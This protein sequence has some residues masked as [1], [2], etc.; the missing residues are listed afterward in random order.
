MVRRPPRASG[1]RPGP[2][3]AL[4][5]AARRGAIF[6]I[7]GDAAPEAVVQPLVKPDRGGVVVADLEADPRPPV[8]AGDTL[9]IGKEG[10]GQPP[11]PVPG[12]DGDRIEPRHGGS[13]AEDKEIV[14]ED[15]DTFADHAAGRG[16]RAHEMPE[17][18]RRQAIR[19]EGAGLQRQ[20][21]VDIGERGGANG[22]GFASS[23]LLLRECDA[24]SRKNTRTARVSSTE[25]AFCRESDR[26]AGPPASHRP[27]QAR[28]RIEQTGPRR[29]QTLTSWRGLNG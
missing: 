25:T 29:H 26:C 7:V 24:D 21:A 2:V 27:S 1:P 17:A 12:I 6:V 15:L 5:I 18:P 23:R 11:P 19:P 8:A 14:A 4:L 9:G 28:P 20:E 13:L 16:R 3:E 10:G 22:R